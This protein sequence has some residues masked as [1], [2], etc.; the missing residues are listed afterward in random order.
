MTDLNDITGAKDADALR[1]VVKE[2][3]QTIMEQLIVSASELESMDLDGFVPDYGLTVSS[4]LPE[5]PFK[6]RTLYLAMTV[7]SSDLDVAVVVEE[8]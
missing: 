3:S 1:A 2:L 5:G 4:P 7:Q 8:D 6:G